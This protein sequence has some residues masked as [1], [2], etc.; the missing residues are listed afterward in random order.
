LATA[1]DL[2]LAINERYAQSLSTEVTEALKDTSQA[3]QK[4]LDVSQLG[5][6]IREAPIAKIVETVL[7]YAMKGRASDVHIE[8]QEDKTRIRYRIDGILA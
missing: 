5:E 7:T 6:V 1:S 4:I 3:N 8:P 2:D